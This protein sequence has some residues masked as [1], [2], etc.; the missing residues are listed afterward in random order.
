M[1]A[2]FDTHCESMT[3]SRRASATIITLRLALFPVV[4]KSFRQGTISLKLDG[5]VEEALSFTGADVC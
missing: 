3:I 1:N 5:W 2:R 4:S